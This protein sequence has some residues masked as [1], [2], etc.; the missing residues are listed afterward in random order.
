MWLGKILWFCSTNSCTC[1]IVLV[2]IE[3]KRCLTWTVFGLWE[4]ARAPRGPA[5]GP[6]FYVGL[7]KKQEKAGFTFNKM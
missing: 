7:K 6:A 1:H 2:K 4:G 3:N 5:Y